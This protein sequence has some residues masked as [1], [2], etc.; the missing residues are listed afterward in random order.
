MRLRSLACRG[1]WAQPFCSFRPAALNI[2]GAIF[3]RRHLRPDPAAD[4][5][6]ALLEAVLATGPLWH[7]GNQSHLKEICLSEALYLQSWTHFTAP[8]RH[9]SVRRCYLSLLKMPPF[10]RVLFSDL[11]RKRAAFKCRGITAEGWPLNAL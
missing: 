9:S 5:C 8:A 3:G 7:A 6:G 4:K 2:Y 10:W 1:C 11:C